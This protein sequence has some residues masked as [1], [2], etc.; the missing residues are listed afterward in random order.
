MAN[1]TPER[2]GDPL[3]LFVPPDAADGAEHFPVR[4]AVVTIGQ[5]PQNDLVL[6]DDTV[7]TRHARL[8]FDDGGW[9]LT[10]LSS[11]NGTYVNG[12]RIA[13]GVPTPLLDEAVVGFGARK[14]AFRVHAEADAEAA[15]AE[16]RP[17]AARTPLTERATFRLPVWLLLMLVIFLVT[18]IALYFWFRGAGEPAAPA[19]APAASLLLDALTRSIS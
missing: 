12:V 18:L 16:Y 6:D 14:L 9:R 15:R 8:E 4:S 19:A 2:S 3:A 5:G 7:S 1:T 17:A 13:A 10:D 11:R